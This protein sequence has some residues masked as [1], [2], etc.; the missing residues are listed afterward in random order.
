[1]QY[2]KIPIQDY[3]DFDITQYFEEAYQIMSSIIESDTKNNILVHCARG[4]CRS[5]AIVTMYLMKKHLWSFKKV[6]LTLNSDTNS[7]ILDS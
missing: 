6:F 5:V 7:K 4:K 1:M 3:S 2:H